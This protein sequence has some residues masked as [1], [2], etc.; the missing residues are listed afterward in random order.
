MEGILKEMAPDFP[1][2]Y[3][4]LDQDLDRLYRKD[5]RIGSLVRYRCVSGCAHR[6]FGVFGV[7]FIYSR[8]ANQGDRDP[9]G[10]GIFCGCDIPAL[11]QTILAL[12]PVGQSVR[13]AAGLFWFEANGWRALPTGHDSGVEIFLLASLVTFVVAIV[14]VSYQALKAALAHPVE[15]LRYE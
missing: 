3:T 9:Q 10:P 5:S 14:T 2:E 8:A 4:F 15:S 12:D 6:L 1:L 13:L 11:R 7:G